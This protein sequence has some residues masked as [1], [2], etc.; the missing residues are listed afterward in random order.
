MT[1]KSTLRKSKEDYYNVIRLKES[2][3]R[4]VDICRETGLG[5]SCVNNWCRGANGKTF[6]GKSKYNRRISTDSNPVEYL[7][8]LNS[9]ISDEVRYKCYSYLLGLYFGDGHIARFERTKRLSV[10]LDVKYRTLNQLVERVFELLFGKAPKIRCRKNGNCIDITHSDCNIGLIFPH[11]GLGV[12]SKR[13]LELFEWQLNLIDWRMFVAGMFHSDGCYYRRPNTKLYYYSFVNTSVDIIEMF[14][15]G[16][17]QIGVS[18]TTNFR[19]SKF[20]DTFVV[21]VYKD[22]SK[23]HNIIGDKVNIPFEF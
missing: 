12:K 1:K 13:K 9:E 23:L 16:L 3:M 14:Q 17:T 8:S 21:N 10:T 11:E 22:S 15:I 4:I 7:K 19:K 18:F 20:S 5:R 2:G 6:T